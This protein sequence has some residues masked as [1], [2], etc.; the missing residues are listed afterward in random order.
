MAA[1][2]GVAGA[3]GAAFWV[4]AGRDLELPMRLAWAMPGRT[5]PATAKAITEAEVRKEMFTEKIQ[6][7]KVHKTDPPQLVL[8]WWAYRDQ[9]G[10][11]RPIASQTWR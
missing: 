5:K 2:A 8:A 1:A 6:S 4:M 9:V 11:M 10:V 7:I 3:A